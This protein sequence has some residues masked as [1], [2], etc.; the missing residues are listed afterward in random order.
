MYRLVCALL[1]TVL[2]ASSYAALIIDGGQHELL[3][4]GEYKIP[5]MARGDDGDKVEG[6]NLYVQITPNEPGTPFITGLDIEGPGTL[7]NPNSAGQQV[8]SADEW[9]WG[10]DNLT[11]SGKLALEDE[12]PLAFLT[13]NTV[14]ANPGVYN[15]LLKKVMGSDAFTSDFGGLPTTVYDGTITVTAVPEPASCLMLACGVGILVVGEFM[16]RRKIST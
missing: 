10:G 5:I 13:V 3:A 15:L 16:R 14:G 8:F 1:C 11:I 12:I 7:F 2:P 4:G 6:V 9:T